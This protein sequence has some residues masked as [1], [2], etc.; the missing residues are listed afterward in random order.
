MVWAKY[1]TG[2]VM[3]RHTHT[4]TN[5]HGCESFN[6]VDWLW[7]PTKSNNNSTSSSSNHHCRCRAANTNESNW[8]L[9]ATFICCLC[10]L[11]FL[12]AFLF[13]NCF[14]ALSILHFI[15]YP[16]LVPIF[17]IT[18]HLRRI[19]LQFWRLFIVCIKSLLLLLLL[20]FPLLLSLSMLACVRVCIYFFPYPQLFVTPKIC[21]TWCFWFQSHLRTGRPNSFLFSLCVFLLVYHIGAL[22]SA[23][24][25]I[26]ICCAIF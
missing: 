1:W 4:H 5:L 15:V 23:V 18:W 9:S 7:Q 14:P 3:K 21:F 8:M 17:S 26:I 12:M 13:S 16:F 2:G 22:L 10:A 25:F 24:A 6:A 11:P 19:R 20:C